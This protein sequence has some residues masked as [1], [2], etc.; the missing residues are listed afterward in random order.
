MEKEQDYKRLYLEERMQRM[1][2]E[3]QALGLRYTNIQAEIP[4]IMKELE[5]YN[6]QNKAK[7]E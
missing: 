3:L 6:R 5:E 7:N 1:Q 2:I 4:I